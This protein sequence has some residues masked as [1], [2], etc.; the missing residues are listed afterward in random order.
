MRNPD[1]RDNTVFCQVRT[2]RIDGLRAL[3][4]QEIVRPIYHS[5]S[6]L[7]FGLRRN[8]PHRRSSGSFGD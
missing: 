3:T 5:R 6:L 1:R 8:E 2:Q 4:N 7:L